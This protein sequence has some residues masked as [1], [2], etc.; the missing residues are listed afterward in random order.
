MRPSVVIS[1]GETRVLV[2]TTPE[3]RLQCVNNDVEKIDSV[4]FTHGHADHVMGL[5]DVRRFNYL[6]GGP[7]DVWADERTF[8]V[9]HLSFAYAFREPQPDMKVF[10]PHLV[11]RP[12]EGPF[13]IEG[14]RWTPVPLM[15]GDM[16]VLGF[17]VGHLA[18][19]TD[20]SFIPE[21]S[22]ELL[23]DLDVLVLDALQYKKHIT[24]FSV[25]QA[26]EAAR[27]IGA[28]QTF[29]THI[30]HSLPHELTNRSLPEG[31]RLAHDGQVVTARL[32]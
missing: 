2:D 30:A 8:H 17:R 11:H 21:A 23:R 26:I 16:P 6:K 3:L 24:H 15:H 32:D 19:C 1:Y 5:D 29:F 31:I 14:V 12:I 20:V 10:R 27:R 7:L 4:V 28:A 18:Y 9:L 13:E 25:E 22:F